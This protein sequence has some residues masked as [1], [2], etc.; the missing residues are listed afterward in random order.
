MWYNIVLRINRKSRFI[1]YRHILSQ[2]ERTRKENKPRPAGEPDDLLVISP[3]F[4]HSLPIY[5]CARAPAK[6]LHSTRVIH[7]RSQ[8]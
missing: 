6:P 3:S 7:Y 1:L 2:R 4:S 5:L 8:A